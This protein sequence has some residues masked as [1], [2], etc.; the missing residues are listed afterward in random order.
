MDNK[1]T[2]TKPTYRV[3]LRWPAGRVSDKTVTQS[4]ERALAAF[5][6]LIHLK[7][8]RGEKVGAALT[9][10]GEQRYYCRFDAKPGERGYLPEDAELEL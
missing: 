9:Q 2:P 6:K 10:D 8:L 4:P 1:Q 3:Y 7:E 5:R